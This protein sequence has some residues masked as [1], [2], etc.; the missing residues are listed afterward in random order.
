MRILFIYFN[1]EFRPRVPFSLTLLETIVKNEGHV[2]DVFDT[3]FY[4]DFLDPWEFNHLKAGIWKVVDNL[5]IEPKK[6][7][8]YEDLKKKVEQFKPDLV[9]FSFYATNVEMQRK[10]LVPLK[11]DYPAVKVL[12]GGVQICLNPEESLKES[13]IDMVCNGEGE[14]LIKEVCKRIDQG[15]DLKDVKGLWL[16]NGNEIIRNGITD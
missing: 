13:Y 11:R 16:N 3:S 14:E 9:A 2:T 5:A 4:V 7:A 1:K 12:A 6:S 15:V 8:P 10:L